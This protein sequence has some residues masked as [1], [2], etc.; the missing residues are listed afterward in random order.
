M[1]TIER[2]TLPSLSHETDQTGAAPG[3]RI[4]VRTT[5]SHLS[6][7][8]EWRMEELTGNTNVNVVTDGACS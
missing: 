4:S 3:L 6:D 5:T 7:Y 1:A 8:P 2:V